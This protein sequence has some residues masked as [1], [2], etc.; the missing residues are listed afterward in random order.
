MLGVSTT[1][2]LCCVKRNGGNYEIG[3]VYKES[4]N[5]VVNI[6]GVTKITFTE[7]STSNSGVDKLMI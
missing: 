3:V 1:P 7:G 6:A 5:Y 2:R 4:S